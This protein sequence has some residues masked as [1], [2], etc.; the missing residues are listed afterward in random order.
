MFSVVIFPKIDLKNNLVMTC[1]FH[2]KNVVLTFFALTFITKFISKK[3]LIKKKIF[4]V[5]FFEIVIFFF[6]R[7]RRI[8]VSFT[9]LYH[10]SISLLVLFIFGLI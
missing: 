8:V 5:L 3:L 1:C 2:G 10:F 9:F 6:C 4:T 7:R